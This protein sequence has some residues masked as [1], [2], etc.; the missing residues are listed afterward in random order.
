M[1]VARLAQ[2][3]STVFGRD[4]DGEG[5]DVTQSL[6]DLFGDL[7]FAVDLVAVHLVPHESL[8]PLQE[9]AGTLDLDGVQLGVWVD[10]VDPEIPIEH[11]ADEAGSLPLLLACGF[12]DFAGFFSV[13]SCGGA[14]GAGAVITSGMSFLRAAA[15]ATVRAGRS[16]R[17]HDVPFPLLEE[18]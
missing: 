8:E 18:G 1:G 17:G 11:L 5:A 13:A 9:R 3:Q 4:L 14:P 7:P 15:E 16:G 6:N 10:Q 2:S 12:R